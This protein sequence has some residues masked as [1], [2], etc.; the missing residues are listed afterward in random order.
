MPSATRQVRYRP[1]SSTV[2]HLPRSP[3]GLADHLLACPRLADI[4]PLGAA[5]GTEARS[6][7]EA[8][9]TPEKDVEIATLRNQLAV[10]RR[11]MARPRY[12]LGSSRSAGRNLS[13]P[14]PFSSAT[15]LV[16]ERWA[17]ALVA[18]ARRSLPSHN[19]PAQRQIP[20]LAPFRLKLRR[21]LSGRKA[22]GVLAQSERYDR[23]I[24]QLPGNVRSALPVFH[25]WR[26]SV[27]P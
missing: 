1:L 7:H 3:S 18:P 22:Q 15:F 2:A 17:A 14:Q 16:R 8:A 27:V 13:R 21:S 12:H 19:R 24:P 4:V 5:L 25:E 10:L 11:Q 20:E 9:E 23:N 6:L 26:G